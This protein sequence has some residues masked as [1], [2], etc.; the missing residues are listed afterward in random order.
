[1]H[2]FRTSHFVHL[3]QL[4]G[5]SRC[6]SPL[7]TS[8]PSLLIVSCERSLINWVE[9]EPCVTFYD[10]DSLF[11]SE[12][13]KL[14]EVSLGW[15][16]SYRSGKHDQPQSR[17][18]SFLRVTV[19]ESAVLRWTR[20]KVKPKPPTSGIRSLQ[21]LASHLLHAQS[22]LSSIDGCAGLTSVTPWK[23]ERKRAVIE[24]A[25]SPNKDCVWLWA[26]RDIRDSIIIVGYREK[27]YV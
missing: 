14:K 8:F 9:I 6:L 18:L 17:S 23:K 27:E 26:P 19:P 24:R 7:F 3:R 12:V 2:V 15:K 1:M 10:T 11:A 20:V 4:T 25:R 21:D 22:N 5:D 13:V 16:Y